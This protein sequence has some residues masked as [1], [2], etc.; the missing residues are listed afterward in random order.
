MEDKSSWYCQFLPDL[1]CFTINMGCMTKKTRSKW[2]GCHI[3][4]V[5]HWIHFREP[6]LKAEPKPLHTGLRIHHRLES[7]KTPLMCRVHY[8]IREHPQSN[9][10]GVYICL[11]RMKWSPDVNVLWQ[12]VTTFCISRNCNNNII[13]LHILY[14]RMVIFLRVQP[15]W[16]A[17]PCSA[18]RPDGST[19]QRP[20]FFILHPIIIDL[21]WS[22][23]F[24]QELKKYLEIS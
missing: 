12:K 19:Q 3:L 13:K 2:I 22:G 17:L 16:I 9:R 24:H 5:C 11:N 21:G 20:Y 8:D 15:H 14:H 6:L 4:V 1:R 18:V 7:C 10:P 23:N